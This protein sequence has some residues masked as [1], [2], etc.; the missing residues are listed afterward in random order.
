MEALRDLV[1]ADEM[2]HIETFPSVLRKITPH[3][4]YTSGSTSTRHHYHMIIIFDVLFLNVR[5]LLILILI[6]ILFLNV[7]LLLNGSLLERL[8]ADN[9]SEA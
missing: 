5:L 4:S 7:R 1:Q 2:V 3:M 8:K 9:N 6:L